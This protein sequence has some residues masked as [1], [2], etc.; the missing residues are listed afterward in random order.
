MR[1][2]KSQKVTLTKNISREKKREV[3]LQS[4]TKYLGLQ[5]ITEC[6]QV[7]LQRFNYKER[8]NDETELEKEKN[9]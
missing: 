2:C 7:K 9:R 6:N 8:K 1:S 3:V 4:I 5:R